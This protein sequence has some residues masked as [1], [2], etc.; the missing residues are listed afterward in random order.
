MNMY[1]TA[2][3]SSTAHLIDR[4]T[5][6]EAHTSMTNAP[7]LPTPLPPPPLSSPAETIYLRAGFLFPSSIP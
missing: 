1:K 4:R 2:A 5:G 6:S 7:R 3:R